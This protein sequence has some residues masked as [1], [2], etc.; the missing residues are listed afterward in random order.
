MR[1][2]IVSSFV[3]ESHLELQVVFISLRELLLVLCAML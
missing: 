2:I 1:L 3:L